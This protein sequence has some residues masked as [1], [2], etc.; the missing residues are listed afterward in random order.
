MNL[1]DVLKFATT[2]NTPEKKKELGNGAKHYVRLFLINGYLLSKIGPG[3]NFESL[4][5]SAEE[6]ADKFIARYFDSPSV[7]EAPIQSTR[8][9]KA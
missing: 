3:A 9:T 8:P 5:F 6:Y 1:N 2:L 7:T 4:C